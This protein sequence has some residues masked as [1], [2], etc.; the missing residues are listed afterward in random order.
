MLGGG[1]FTSQNKKLPG[2]YINFIG[3]KKATGA[4]SD[5]G[6]AAVALA[7]SWGEL[8]TVVKVSRDEVA[9]NSLKLF[10]VPYND[11]SMLPI[12]EIF[13]HAK[14]LLVY[15]LGTGG[16]AASNTYGTAK[17]VGT[18]GN[19]IITVIT[20][21]TDGET[22]T[23]WNVQTFLGTELVDEQTVKGTD[24]TTATLKNNDYVA[25]KSNV[26][27]AEATKTTGAMSGGVD[28]T[29]ATSHGDFLSALE[30]QAFHVLACSSTTA[31]IIAEYVAFIK[32]FRDKYGVKSQVVVHRTAGDHEGVINVVNNLVGESVASGK[33]VFWVAG[34]E[35]G[36]AVNQSCTN[37]T[38][39]GELEIDTN[40]DQ[41]ALESALDA[42][43]FIFHQV[44]DNV[45]VL[46]DI[47]SLVSFTDTKTE[48]FRYN[49]TI[50]VLDQ[51]A[52]DTKS[53]YNTK[54]IGKIPND[55]SGRVSL[56][57]D[58][59]SMCKSLENL[60]AIEDFSADNVE[61]LPGDTKRAVVANMAITP[62]NAMAQ[63]YQTVYVS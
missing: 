11:A 5:R 30:N 12:R 54:Y 29:A 21:T 41:S 20:A 61:V 51:I 39:D 25:W 15:R 53:L 13:V 58:I 18:V 40:Y 35:A 2:A 23:G 17:Y 32:D 36:C 28:P 33:A 26:T 62:V 52:N 4:L 59:V 56:W 14:E 38:Y 49:Q 46:E 37:M 27:L 45:N 42:G 7:L 8:G 60:R 57:N 16:T 44:G 43:Q 3:T 22:S 6:T 19:N 24:L 31:A 47:N 55:K 10:G 34:A 1:I 9:K 50:R 48:D 63:L